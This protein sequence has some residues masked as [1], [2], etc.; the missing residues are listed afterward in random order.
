MTIESLT[1]GVLAI[2]LVPLSL[3]IFFFSTDPVP[4]TKHRRRMFDLRTLM[5]VS[6]ILLSQKFTL[7]AVILF[8]FAS[9]LFGDWP[10]REWLALV[11]Y[12]ALTYIA[13][14]AFFDLRRS[15]RS[16]EAFMRGEPRDDDTPGE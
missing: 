3:F 1:L 4:G 13:F 5:P 7:I 9:R 15:Q 16:Q 2:W 12:A 11:L 10:G 14:L 8:V 6:K